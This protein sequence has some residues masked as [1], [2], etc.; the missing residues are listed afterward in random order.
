VRSE[1]TRNG[2]FDRRSKPGRNSP[3]P[4]RFHYA[5]VGL[6]ALDAEQYVR[7][8]NWLGVALAALMD[9]TKERRIELA[10]EALERIVHSPQNVCR[11]I[12]LGSSAAGDS[13]GCDRRLRP[14]VVWLINH[15]KLR[16]YLND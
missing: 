9:V 11:K 1:R 16:R 8:H 3:A 2:V 15:G 5:Y 7:Q 10:G 13:C 14:S 12:L 4:V 6:P